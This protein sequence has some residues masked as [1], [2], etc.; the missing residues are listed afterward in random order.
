MTSPTPTN[1]NPYGPAVIKPE[2]PSTAVNS[3]IPA[4]VSTTTS[5]TVIA[6]SQDRNAAHN[7]LVLGNYGRKAGGSKRKDRKKKSKNSKKSKR[8]KHHKNSKRTKKTRRHKRGGSILTATTTTPTPS[9]KPSVAP[10]PQFS[11]A[12]NAGA[13]AN[14]LTG[15]KLS[16]T[17]GAQKV[18]DDTNAPPSNTVVNQ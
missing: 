7:A 11:G 18:F 12:H 3:A 13:S 6:A 17:V 9:P 5:S 1:S 15:N 16:M 10:V 2:I 8:S 14:S 4:T